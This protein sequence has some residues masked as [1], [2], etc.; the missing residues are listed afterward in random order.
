VSRHC[1]CETALASDN[2]IRL[3]SACQAAHRRAGR[4]GGVLAD[5]RD[6]HCAGERR[7][8][9]GAA[10]LPLS[11]V[12]PPASVTGTYRRLAAHEPG[13]GLPTRARQ[14]ARDARRDHQCRA[15]AWHAGHVSLDCRASQP[16][17]RR[18]GSHQP[19]RPVRHGRR[20]RPGSHHDECAPTS[21]PGPLARVPVAGRCQ[22]G[23]VAATAPR[24]RPAR[25]NAHAPRRTVRVRRRADRPTDVDAGSHVSEA[26]LPGLPLRARGQRTRMAALRPATRRCVTRRR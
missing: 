2:T 25:C 14:T 1:R 16:S 17:G 7:S 22:G 8:R 9:T 10:R 3:C 12:P 11:H 26:E 13:R 15:S 23:S 20:S 5:R 4:A 19:S 18:R 6:G 21:G 24:I